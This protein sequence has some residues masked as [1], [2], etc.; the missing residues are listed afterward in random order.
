M[1]LFMTKQKKRGRPKGSKNKTKTA[2]KKKTTVKK[3]TPKKVAVKRGRPKGSKNKTKKPINYQ[4][5][6]KKFVKSHGG[7]VKG[8]F[9]ILNGWKIQIS[10]RPKGIYWHHK[11]EGDFKDSFSVMDFYDIRKEKPFTP[12]EKV[13]QELLDR[14]LGF[15]N[16]KK[17]QRVLNKEYKEMKAEERRLSQAGTKA[18]YC[19]TCN[20]CPEGAAS[21]TCSK[22]IDNGVQIPFC[23]EPKFYEDHYCHN[24]YLDIPKKKTIHDGQYFCRKTEDLCPYQTKTEL[25]GIPILKRNIKD[26]H[27]TKCKYYIKDIEEAA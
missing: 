24:A 14:A 20:H 8:K 16:L 22:R 18:L 2:P 27:Y 13:T 19:S 1:E 26:E 6:I 12:E 4:T 7:E 23:S 11:L 9:F 3:V 10:Q 17:T 5:Q 21:D 25:G 15:I